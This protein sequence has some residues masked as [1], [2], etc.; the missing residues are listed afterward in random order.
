M[1]LSIELD[2]KNIKY[3]EVRLILTYGRRLSEGCALAKPRQLFE[4]PPRHRHSDL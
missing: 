1:L 2:D 4:Q 3:D